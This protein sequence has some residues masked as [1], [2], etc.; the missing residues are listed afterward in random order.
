MT[1]QTPLPG[2]VPPTGPASTSPAGPRLVSWLVSSGLVGWVIAYNIF[3]IAGRS[4]R[5]AAWP[6]LLV[7]VG[8]G[9]VIFGVTVLVW[10]RYVASGRIRPHGI[11]EI[12]PPE[13]LD[14]RQRGAVDALW[15][16]VATLGV[17]AL[18]VGTV[19]AVDWF[20]TDGNRSATKIV[21]AAW[22]LLVGVWLML[23]AV[24]LRRRHGD[25][26]ESIALAAMLT[27]VLAGVAF[28]QGMFEPAQVAL[29]VLAGIVGA[30]AH[31]ASWRL[32]GSRG[33]PLG[34]A[35]ALGV[36][37]LAIVFPIVF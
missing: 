18:G 22:D 37:A 20:Q 19:L 26:V 21:L 24:E 23:E 31:F 10:R 35:V 15:P 8:L 5:G 9:A 29:I 25:A 1:T 4:P 36:A 17:V 32:L 11:E 27:A 6:S 34:S 28:S 13:R 16:A 7:G 12:P 33:V 2:G 3:R 14:Q 30:V